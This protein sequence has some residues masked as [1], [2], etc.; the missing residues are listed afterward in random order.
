M[1]KIQMTAT[2]DDELP[3]EDTQK[4]TSRYR[5]MI[6][7]DVVFGDGDEGADVDERKKSQRGQIKRLSKGRKEPNKRRLKTPRQEGTA[8]SHKKV[9]A[10]VLRRLL[11]RKRLTP[12]QFTD[13]LFRGRPE[14]NSK[15]KWFLRLLRE[16]VSK[17]HE[18]TQPDLEKVAHEFGVELDDLWDETTG[19]YNVNN[20]H[21]YWRY[22]EKFLE[23]LDAGH[24]YLF[25]LVDTVY[26]A[27]QAAPRETESKEAA[28][29]KDRP[30]KQSGSATERK[31]PRV[32]SMRDFLG[33]KKSQ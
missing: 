30:V 13:R 29:L 10:E 12:R 4:E 22:A 23:L 15:H 18:D 17:V 8:E 1:Q 21:R 7:D 25:D 11:K 3:E 27:E 28:P 33:R 2:D 19:A 20:R 5:R 6:A 16:G 14:K 9:F 24:R 32:G 26:A 31:A